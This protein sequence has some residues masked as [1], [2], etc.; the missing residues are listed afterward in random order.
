MV[1]SC[2]GT[3]GRK[4]G[5]TGTPSCVLSTVAG[6]DP[7]RDGR[8]QDGRQC[9]ADPQLWSTG[10]EAQHRRA[11]RRL[12]SRRPDRLQH[13]GPGPAPGRSVR[14]GLLLRRQVRLQHLPRQP[15]LGAVRG[16]PARLQREQ[17]P[18]RRVGRHDRLD[19]GQEHRP[20]LHLLR[21]VG[22]LLARRRR[23]HRPEGAERA[24]H[25]GAGL[26]PRRRH[27]QRGRL[28]RLRRRRVPDRHARV[29]LGRHGARV[30]PRHRR[31]RGR[32]LRAAGLLPGRR[33]GRAQPHHQHEPGDA[34]VEAVRQPGDA[35][36]DGNRRLRRLQ[37]GAEA[38]GLEQLRRRRSLR[39]RRHLVARHLPAGGQ[40]PHARQLAAVLPGLLHADEDER[41]AVRPAHVP[42]RVRGRLQRRRQGRHP[43]PQRERDPHLPLER[44]AA[45]RRL[46][47][48]GA[49]A[50]ARGSSR[51]ATA[52]SSATS[53]ATARTRWPSSTARTG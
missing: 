19:D 31:A 12:R 15:D 21:L 39:G 25:V 40:L 7:A 52:S 6:N 43:R 2:C 11:R 32:V 33:A 28:R 30:R 38:R 20:R 27:P 49:G 3:H 14:A 45:R 1:R 29:E 51:L 22:A 42:E 53:T 17:H 24:R 26:R 35:G 47:R 10:G 5:K 50:R 37:R 9:H 16:Q 23:R 36:S 4:A 44:F 48:R 13:Q 34:Q 8:S 46:Q 18:V 41:G